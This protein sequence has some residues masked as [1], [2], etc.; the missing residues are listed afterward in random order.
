MKRH[1]R[2]GLEF[3]GGAFAVL[4]LL[5]AAA[6]LILAN[7]SVELDSL[8]PLIAASLSNPASG[9]HVTIAEARLTLARGPRLEI[10]ARNVGLSV[11]AGGPQVALPQIEIDLGVRAALRGVIAPT[12]VTLDEPRLRL[13]RSEAGNFHLGFEMAGTM[14]SESVLAQIL[15]D[16]SGPPDPTLPAGALTELTIK[17]AAFLFDDRALHVTWRAR[18]DLALRRDAS[19]LRGDVTLAAET[20]VAHGVIRAQIDYVRDASRLDAQLDFR[21]L[22]PTNWAAATAAMAPLRGID[23]PIS[24]NAHVTLDPSRGAIVAASCDVKLGAGAWRDPALPGGGVAV[25][26]G[27]VVASYDPA[28]GRIALETLALGLD[29]PSLLARGTIDGAGSG[30]LAGGWPRRLD[31]A[32]SVDTSA[33]AVG[34]LPRLWPPGI[35]PQ[36]RQWVLSHVHDGT[37][38][39]ASAALGLHIDLDAADPIELR[40]LSGTLNYRGIAMDIVGTLPPAQGISG[41]AT[42]DRAAMVLTSASGTILGLS[43]GDAKVLLTGFDM[44]VTRASLDLAFAGPIKDALTLLGSKPFDYARAIPVAP[45]DVAGDIRGHL[46]AAFPIV[47]P[48]D[49]REIDVAGDATLTGVA[50]PHAVLGHDV[51]AGAFG[52]TLSRDAVMLDGTAALAAVPVTLS[53]RVSLADNPAERVTA[54]LHVRLDDKARRALASIFFPT[55]CAGRSG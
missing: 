47:D 12:R 21:D 9:V 48:L 7:G 55:R 2:L 37:I 42:F 14:A 6:A 27:A 16:L 8:A 15:R 13:E 53:A 20:A 19:G 5:V 50:I 36:T 22:R 43:L 26:G 3:L 4:A 39:R 46:T 25:M 32:L 44:P 38:D 31:A 24:G 10:V 51:G 41:T 28:Q 52:L 1:T 11:G 45:A 35:L 49:P 30:L 18:A 17:E 29:G 23:L 40:T 33:I 54:D 34:A